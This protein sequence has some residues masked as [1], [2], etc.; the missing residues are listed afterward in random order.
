MLDVALRDIDSV[1]A[2]AR[3]KTEQHDQ[4][5]I[6]AC[7]PAGCSLQPDEI[8]DLDYLGCYYTMLPQAALNVA[9][10][11]AFTLTF[12]SVDPFFD[13]RAISVVVRDFGDKG[14]ERSANFGSVTIDGCRY[15]GTNVAPL[16]AT[17]TQFWTSEKWNPRARNG[18]ACPVCWGLFTNSA[19]GY[20]LVIQG[21]N[22]NAFPIDV[23]AEVY[24]ESLR[25]AP[26]WCDEKDSQ[27][28]RRKRIPR[29]PGGGAPSS[30]TR[31]AG[32]GAAFA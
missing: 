3:A 22:P 27:T 6:G 20:P 4:C 8:Y 28:F 19:N 24:G 23:I 1:R 31:A 32:R 11:T 25:C 18:C 21:F 30:N 16:T 12:N 5:G 13:P 7:G 26:D 2:A 9:A 29:G 17:S 10:G 15:E 14:L